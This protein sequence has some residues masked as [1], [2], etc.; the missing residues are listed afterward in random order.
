MLRRTLRLAV[1]PGALFGIALF[2]LSLASFG[3][4]EYMGV[5]DD[6]LI[7][8]VLGMFTRELVL[9]QAQLLGIAVGTGIGLATF[10]FSGLSAWGTLRGR[11]PLT[12]WRGPAAV[13]AGCALIH[14]GFLART[15]VE[16]PQVM[17]DAFF[18]K[19]GVSAWIQL[20]L[21]RYTTPG[22]WAALGWAAL[23]SWAAL[24]GLAL[25]RTGRP[26]VVLGAVGVACGVLTAG[27]TV[28]AR[29]V[30]ASR[31]NLLV[32]AVDSLRPDFMDQP[33][34]TP[35]LAALEAVRFD[36]AYSVMARTFPSWVSMLTGAYPHN[37]G[38]RHM[39]PSPE[40]LATRR[41][42]VIS[43]LRRAGYRTA[44]V[45]DF[46]GDIFSRIE[47]GF[48]T[49]RVPRFTLWSNVALGGFKLHY[50]LMPYLLHVLGAQRSFPIL[51]L[52]ERLADPRAVTEE[53][54][55]YIANGDE[56]P[57]ALVLFYSGAH[58]PYAA[59]WPWYASDT[60][61]DYAGDSRFHKAA[62]KD[63][64]HAPGPEEQQQARALYTGAVRGTDA[65][66][67]QLFEHLR[68]SGLYDK[69]HIVV[70]A[71]HGENLYEEGFGV[72]H[73]DHLR[74]TVATR[75]PLLVKPAG[76][77][78]SRVLKNTVRSL[79]L[80]PTLAGL[81]GLDFAAQ[82]GRSLAPAVLEGKALGEDPPVFMET[83]L[84]FINPEAAV[85]SGRTLSFMQGF[86][87]FVVHPESREIYL[88]P[89]L[90]DDFLV[91][92]HRAVLHQGWKLLYIPTRTK[93]LYELYHTA[94]D[95]METREL[96]A[97]EPERLE[98]MK[99]LLRS[100]IASDPNLVP[101]GEWFI[102]RDPR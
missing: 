77:G 9:L 92:K 69:T 15:M 74:G 68:H 8:R 26:R 56:R 6:A 55:D 13:L 100:F 34:V 50:H 96:S 3:S 14:A 43:E 65:A 12:G 66:I 49:V 52:W 71:D 4:G 20:T 17:A 30:I 83:G 91:A 82:D 97:S 21:T 22:F 11:P 48:E 45:S 41:H 35:N 19:G 27:L 24:V 44:V 23:L 33:G 86:G 63:A 39:F 93:V 25:W 57:F 89:R 59:P 53:A 76:G 75:I 101:A 32:V 7:N 47:L 73:G 31:P 88:D 61:P 29:P 60:D 90:D 98:A 72:G 85:L 10:V 84:W 67:G 1:A 54:W 28:E 64:D 18:A 102:A 58:F 81:V 94:A 78:A 46:A 62:W 79:D 80:A 36:S 37:H 5:K 87:A 16:F 51:K 40:T 38:V 42:T 99:K 2:A 95:P 70:T